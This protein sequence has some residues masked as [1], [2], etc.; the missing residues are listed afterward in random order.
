MHKHNYDFFSAITNPD[1]KI[2]AKVK[3]FFDCLSIAFNFTNKHYDFPCE[4][5]KTV[6]KSIYYQVKFNDPKY[7]KRNI[8]FS[9]NILGI[10]NNHYRIF[11]Y[12]SECL[13]KLKS[14]INLLDEN[15]NTPNFEE[16]IFPLEDLLNQLEETYFSKCLQKIINHILSHEELDSISNNH[17]IIDCILFHTKLIAVDFY[18]TGA[19]SIDINNIVKNICNSSKK[20]KEQIRHLKDKYDD[21]DQYFKN[22]QL[23]DQIKEVELIYCYFKSKQTATF[24]IQPHS[25][26]KNNLDIDFFDV[27]FTSTLPDY[28]NKNWFNEDYDKY[29]YGNP[30]ISDK[31]IFAIVEMNN[32]HS[33]TI[34]LARDKV[35]VA[36]NT[37]GRF[38][39]NQYIIDFAYKLSNASSIQNKENIDFDKN[40]LIDSLYIQYKKNKIIIDEAIDKFL[41]DNDFLFITGRDTKKRSELLTNLWFYLE[42]YYKNSD[43]A[44]KRSSFTLA[45]RVKEE[46]IC[47]L[48]LFIDN[49]YFNLFNGIPIF[50]KDEDRHMYYTNLKTDMKKKLKIFKKS[51]RHP[52]LT[53]KFITNDNAEYSEN[54]KYQDFIK[55]YL[56]KVW[57]NRN[58]YVHSLKENDYFLGANLNFLL[59]LTN[60]F[61]QDL[62]SKAIEQ[63]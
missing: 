8:Y 14:Y 33:N 46:F 55:E 22:R 27:K 42:S 54:S 52:I 26:L 29:K 9:L 10:E 44:I 30:I 60:Y 53:R 16:Y 38:T 1:K 62:I 25:K 41:I 50:V 12:N 19:S 36:I 43:D 34:N 58:L 31:T 51:F 24:F 28:I 23:V 40:N 37:L 21:L 13:S 3:Y 45:D 32:N 17:S 59:A 56:K 2:E 15:K 20:H 7:A 4:N 6:I 18:L 47:S 11:D 61:R 39:E 49:K 5:H 57:I 35:Q 48:Y 63:K